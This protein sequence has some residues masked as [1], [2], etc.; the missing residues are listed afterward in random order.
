VTVTNCTLSSACNAI[1][2]GVGEGLISEA[3][4]S[5]I[6]IYNTKNAFNIVSGY[7]R[8]ER[9]TDITDILF[10]NIRVN[11]ER[12]MKIHHMRGDEGVFR[13]ITFSNISG[14][15]PHD[16]Q[17]W[18]KKD[19]PFSDITF[20]DIDVPGSFECI[21]ASVTVKGGQFRLKKLPGKLLKERK[22]NIENEKKLL[23]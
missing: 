1:R 12:L 14:N 6:A 5:N 19:Y 17:I 16:S 23:Y 21:N 9:G 4:F 10:S 8:T 22:W 7:T 18:A 2:L 13:N 20:R 15:A 11:A 3:T